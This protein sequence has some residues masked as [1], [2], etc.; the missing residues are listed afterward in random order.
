M[1]ASRE[2]KNRQEVAAS[3]V[4]D[5]KTARQA[6]EQAKERRSN[7]LYAIIAIAFVVVAIGLVVWNSNI[8]QRGTTAV[9][10]EGESYSAAEVSYYYHNAYNSIVNSKYASLYG[11]DKNTSLSQ[12][13]LND[14]AKMMLRVS[15]DMTWDAYF[16]DAAK[17][18]LIQLTMLKKGAAEKG[19]TFNDDM[20]KEVDSTVETFST[21][22]KKAGYSTSAYLKLMYGNNMTMSTFKS[23]L[24]DTL[25]ASHYQQ[26]YID[27]LTY[28]DEEV[29]TYY[30]EHKNNFDVADYEYIYFKG[31]ADSTKDAD[32]NT[33][34]PTDEENAA[35]KEAA[36]ANANA[37]LEAV[38]NGLLME[39][40]A[41][42]Y[43]N[44]TYTDRPTGT[45]SGDAVTEWV[46]N[47]ERQEGDLTLIESGDNYYVVLFH[48]RGRNDYNTV[49]VRHILFKVDTS[50][51]DSKA[52]DYQEK[53]DARKA[54]Q[55]EAADQES[56]EE[57][58]VG[59]GWKHVSTHEI[60]EN[61]ECLK[62]EYYA[63][64]D[65]A[66]PSYYYFESAAS[67]KTFMHV[68]A[69]P[70]N[71][72]RTSAYKYI[73][74]N[75]VVVNNQHM[76]WQILSVDKDLLKAVEYLGVRADGIK[77]YGYV[78]YKR[79]TEQELAECRESYPVDLSNL[80]DLV[81][82]VTEE[83]VFVNGKE[84]EFDVL[85][86]NGYNYNCVGYFCQ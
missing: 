82:S 25:L 64:L 86:S 47:E 49:D 53:L 70:V 68:D 37:A 2:K 56:F 63:G 77:V 7:R 67:L 27:S 42:N 60:K 69:Y 19:M 22:A 20:Q 6:Q 14:T 80:K 3:G 41:G 26:D 78:T 32:G 52:D 72:F 83:N 59:Y 74:A 84:F 24:K 79:M 71:G 36:S 81:I 40:A 55:K 61:G 5:P 10:V 1:S 66:G 35:A 11:I 34:K 57:T 8:I 50:D 62:E 30:N 15:E 43:D 21:Y 17:K 28:T 45:Y 75:R 65:G 9:T 51:L 4:A 76:I 12:Q 48:S 13:S 44:G 18:S 16:R 73:D 38:R 54:E 23:I 85:E 58:V 31:T 46:F 39:K 29:E 33:V